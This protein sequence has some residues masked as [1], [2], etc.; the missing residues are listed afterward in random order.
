MPAWGWTG[1]VYGIGMAVV[2]VMGY[3]RR[4]VPAIVASALYALAS[5]G[6]A[7]VDDVRAQVV[8]PAAMTLAGYWLS[9]LFVGPPQPRLERWLLQSDRQLF[10]RL[11]ID[12][13]LEAAPRWVLD[14]IEFIY[15]TVYLV[16]AMGALAMAPLGRDAVLYYWAIV[17]PAELVCCAALPFFRCRPPRSL[18]PDDGVIARRNPVMR[19]LN[20]VIVNRGSIQVNTFPSAHVAAAL[21]AGLAMSSWQPFAGAVVIILAAL[22]G[23]AATVGRYHYGVDCL[24]GA[25]VA[26]VIWFVT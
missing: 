25:V 26:V 23:V 19:R 2:A 18:E 11:R 10:T 14:L 6:F 12:Q 16:V 5:A 24:F 15:S 3:P 8:L 7:M 20:T 9:G 21:A 4:R 1:V 22:I 17:V 13:L